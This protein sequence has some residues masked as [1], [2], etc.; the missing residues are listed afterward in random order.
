MGENG[1][2]LHDYNLQYMFNRINFIIFFVSLL[3]LGL[4]IKNDNNY[5]VT[6]CF[7]DVEMDWGIFV[8]FLP[9]NN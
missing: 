8:H 6:N 9:F 2:H 7:I 1:A 4:K 5:N 3:K